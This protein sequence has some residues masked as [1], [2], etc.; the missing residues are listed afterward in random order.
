VYECC[1]HPCFTDDFEV[2]IFLTEL[3]TPH[4]ILLRQKNFHGKRE[5]IKS[6]SEKM[7]GTREVPMQVDEYADEEEAM[8]SLMRTES[9]EEEKPVLQD[10]HAAEGGASEDVTS[11]PGCE[12]ETLFISDH[13]EEDRE[14]TADDA[15]EHADDKKKLALNTT[16]HGFRIYGRI[17]CLVVKRKGIVK[18]KQLTGGTGQA[19]MEEWIVSTQEPR[20]M[21]D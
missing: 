11:G 2:S 20:V 14:V 4:S 19:M 1:A 18:G 13:S 3:S 16:Y 5:K 9:T 10:I 15:A 12:G 17:L 7:T 8:A 6:T 21:D